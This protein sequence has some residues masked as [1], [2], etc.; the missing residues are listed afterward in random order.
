MRD[1]LPSGVTLEIADRAVE[2]A[3]QVF[4]GKLMRQT[5]MPSGLSLHAHDG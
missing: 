2:R 5:V 3:A 4:N 1:P